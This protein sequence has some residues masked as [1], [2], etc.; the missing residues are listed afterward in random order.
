MNPSVSCSSEERG[1]D[2]SWVCESWDN[3]A[4]AAPINAMSVGLE[5]A[6]QFHGRVD[7]DWDN[8]ATAA[9]AT[10]NN[11][12][13]STSTNPLLRH[14]H[15]HH[16]H[17]QS[18]SDDQKP[19]IAV[20]PPMAAHTVASFRQYNGMGLGY[21]GQHHHHPLG[22]LN[23]SGMRSFGDSNSGLA[24]SSSSF[25]QSLLYPEMPSFAY[26]G[27]DSR[28]QLAQMMSIQNHHH[29]HGAGAGTAVFHDIVK[30]ED[31]EYQATMLNLGHRAYFSSEDSAVSRLYK[32]SRALPP[33]SQAPRCQAEGCKTDLTNAKHYHRR[34]KV[35]EFHSKA[36]TVITGGVHQRFCQQCSRFHAL[37][38][39][40]EAKRSCRKRL[41]DHNRRR[42]KPQPNA[43]TSNTETP[44]PA[45]KAEEDD[46]SHSNKNGSGSSDTTRG[47]QVAP[48]VRTES[49][50]LMSAMS[51][52]L[53]LQ[54]SKGQMSPNPNASSANCNANPNPNGAL[55]QHSSSHKECQQ[56]QQQYSQNGP[57]L[58]MGLCNQRTQAQQEY[59]GLELALPW[60]RPG[61][62]YSSSHHHRPSP[63]MD[64]L[65]PIMSE[66]SDV[67]GYSSS[68]QNFLPLSTS[69]SRDMGGS[70]QWMVGN[71]DHESGHEHEQQMFSLLESPA[72]VRT[73]ED[74][75]AAVEYLSHR[76]H[77]HHHHHH[78]QGGLGLNSKDGTMQSLRPFGQSIYDSTL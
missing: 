58:S 29:K 26:G 43:V 62:E 61:S 40:D 74:S 70:S 55:Q 64:I 20:Q 32:R 6:R 53:M 31:L 69:S 36:A 18:D 34:H 45:L 30:R 23:S 54:N 66:K 3:P 47:V 13:N 15:H 33:S 63:P 72:A 48:P 76:R 42:R 75:S 10:V 49:Q 24:S 51:L 7:W 57:N 52:P 4:V 60:L 5:T 1:E 25:H 11:N 68:I 9:A 44:T 71:S 41:A 37:S 27:C 17:E 2:N 21:S 78:H 19:H 12:N 56:Q 77:H 39:F 67:E 50:A 16:H 28:S 14:H 35:C 65:H 46:H 8:S 59:S 22:M 38:E 73:E